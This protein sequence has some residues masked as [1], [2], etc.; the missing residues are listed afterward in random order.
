MVGDAAGELSGEA[1]GNVSYRCHA[2]SSLADDKAHDAYSDDRTHPTDENIPV[3]C[4]VTI[5][6]GPEAG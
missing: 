2:S 3:N 6:P 4:L 5:K 1:V